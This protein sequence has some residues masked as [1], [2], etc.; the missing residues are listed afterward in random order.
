MPRPQN[1]LWPALVAAAAPFAHRGFFL[2]PTATLSHNPPAR[3]DARPPAKDVAVPAAAP[4][5]LLLLLLLLLLALDRDGDI[6][7]EGTRSKPP[8][9]NTP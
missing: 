3:V 8:R 7:A 6:V 4:S 5:Y 1:A 9:D 2:S